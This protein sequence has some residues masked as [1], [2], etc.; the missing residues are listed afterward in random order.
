MPNPFE[1]AEDR[2]AG[3]P[4]GDHPAVSEIESALLGC[5]EVKQAAV[6]VRDH[7]PGGRRLVA[8]VVLKPD[9]VSHVPSL[10]AQIQT[11]LPRHLVPSVFSFVEAL[12][13]ASN[14]EIDRNAIDRDLEH[15]GLTATSARDP[16][17]G[18]GSRDRQPAA[19]PMSIVDCLI[20]LWRNALRTQDITV[21]DD[22]FELGG[23]SL[24]AVRL[25][26][27]IRDAL[28]VEP[29]I[30]VIFDHPTPRQLAEALKSLGAT[31]T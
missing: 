14:G 31:Q 7:R 8:C 17:F 26:P 4:H 25:V 20:D 2:T 28:G 5:R 9:C 19:S 6:V 24:I 11:M 29:H 1:V 30:S 3:L 15:L 22:F 27:L 12:P 10:L 21:D 13:L 23:N 16:E 18:D